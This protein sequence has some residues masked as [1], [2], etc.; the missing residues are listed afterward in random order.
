MKNKVIL[1]GD[2]QRAYAAKIIA[3]APEKAVV[4]IAQPNRTNEQNAKVWAMLTDISKH[5][6][7]PNGKM[8]TP[9]AWK[10]IIMQACGHVCQFELGL[11][12]E[13]FPVGHRSSNLTISQ[14]ADLI[15]FM[16]AFGAEQGVLWSEPEIRR[17]AA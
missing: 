16:Y 4:T 11:D 5:G 1:Y 2:S 10:G 13:V 9:D 14:C 7:K 6:P 3:E 15:E 17:Q 12:G 8:G